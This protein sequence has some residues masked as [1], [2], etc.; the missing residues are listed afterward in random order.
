MRVVVNVR[1]AFRYA[2]TAAALAAAA[3][4]GP[5][6]NVSPTQPTSTVPQPADVPPGTLTLRASPIDINEIR[7]ITPLGN[8]NP[9]GHTTPTDHIYFYFANPST[10][11]PASRR[12]EFRAPGDGVVTTVLG[13][14]GQES[15][16]FVRQTSTFIY[17]LDHLILTVPLERN[18]RVTAGQVLGTTGAAYGIDLGVI[19][20]TLT[21]NFVA[22]SRYIYDTIHTDAPLKYFEEPLKSAL[23]SRV[24]R[25]GSERD[26]RIDYDVAGRL[27]GNWFI[28]NSQTAAAAFAYDTYDP[29]RVVICTAV[30]TLQGVWNIAATDPAPRDVSPSTG[31]VLYTL[32]RSITGPPVAT[33]VSGYMLIEM[34]DAT[35]IKMETFTAR[36]ADFTAAAGTFAR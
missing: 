21:L 19:N 29:D 26:G 8:L 32:S 23:Y 28:A 18:S 35:H 10:E 7:F 30:G 13:G 14:L 9:P 24:Q 20:D 27:A 1:S 36:P 33:T 3:C 34:T 6:R 12:M 31:R 22:P 2:A 4:S 25:I 16:V 15:K 5:N 11:Q 17:Y